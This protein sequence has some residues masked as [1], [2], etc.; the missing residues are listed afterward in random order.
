MVALDQAW[1][2]A[3]AT[4]LLGEPD[5]STLNG[6]PSVA[7]LKVLAGCEE[8]LPVYLFALRQGEEFIE[9]GNAEVV[10][11][12]IEALADDSFPRHLFIDLIRH[13]ITLDVPIFGSSI[14]TAIVTH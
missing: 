3:Y 9:Q 1:G 8:L 10:G 12:A 14:V 4:R 6:E 2:C 5:T 13:F 7:A 11:Q